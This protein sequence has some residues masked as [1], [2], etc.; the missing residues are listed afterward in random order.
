MESLYLLPG[1]LHS[2]D[3]LLT[4]KFS[5]QSTL[6]VC[7]SLRTSAVGVTPAERERQRW[8]AK[9]RRRRNKRRQGGGDMSILRTA[10]PLFPHR[11]SV[12]DTSSAERAAGKGGRWGEESSAG[13]RWEEICCIHWPVEMMV[14]LCLYTNIGQLK[15]VW[16]IQLFWFLFQTT[17]RQ[18]EG[19]MSLTGTVQMVA[20]A[21]VGK[22]SV[23]HAASRETS[24]LLHSKVET[25]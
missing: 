5:F 23:L 18:H 24:G 17:S 11:V 22:R 2:A 7:C 4:L 13:G 12:Q 8:Q 16:N 3:L 15:E 14:F 10:F 25:N 9:W 1:C 6:R 19:T 20:E 21:V